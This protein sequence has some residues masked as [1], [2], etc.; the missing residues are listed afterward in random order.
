MSSIPILTINDYNF[1]SERPIGTISVSA[2]STKFYPDLEPGKWIA[3]DFSALFGGKSKTFTASLENAI[4]D[5]RDKL[6]KEL[7]KNYPNALSVIGLTVS[8]ST[9]ILLAEDLYPTAIIEFKDIGLDY[10]PVIIVVMTGTVIG[11]L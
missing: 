8:L 10:T 11:P 2:V 5:A 1:K 6:N 7:A 4:N 9:E 3:A